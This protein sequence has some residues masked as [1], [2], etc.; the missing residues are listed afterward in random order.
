MM[1]PTAAEACS[2]PRN[3]LKS[4]G[5]QEIKI[6]TIY[7]KPGTVTTPD[8]FEKEDQP[9]DCF[10]MGSQRNPDEDKAQARGQTRDRLRKSRTWCGQASPRHWLRNCL[11]TAERPVML[12][13]IEEFGVYA[14]NN[15]VQRRK[16]PRCRSFPEREPK[17]KPPRTLICSSST[18]T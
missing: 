4:S 12:H 9:L 17:K 6:A 7:C 18:P 14:G 13:H 16:I 15:R 5:A 1:F 3:I 8:Y 11:K 10:S 2:L